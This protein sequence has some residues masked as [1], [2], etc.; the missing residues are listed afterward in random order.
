MNRQGVER[1]LSAAWVFAGLLGVSAPAA[2]LPEGRVRALEHLLIQDCGSCHGLRL[3][4]GLGPALTPQALTGK[5]ADY[6]RE[7]I[8]NG[9]PGTAMPPWQPLLS[10]AEAEWLAKRLLNG[11][12]DAR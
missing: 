7:V 5:S 8:L 11:I 2:A 6:L 12:S 1:A 9:V 3:T 10:P 4:G